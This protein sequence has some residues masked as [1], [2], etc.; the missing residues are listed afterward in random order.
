MRQVLPAGVAAL[1]I[2]LLGACNGQTLAVVENSDAG[3]LDNRKESVSEAEDSDAIGAPTASKVDVLFV[4][5]NSASMSDKSEILAQSVAPFL[6]KVASSGDVHVGVISSSLGGMGGDVCSDDGEQNGRSHLRTLDR[7]TE[8]G[9]FLKYGP[10]GFKDLDGF[11]KNAEELVRKVGQDGCGF[12]AQLE[13]AYRFLAQPDPWLTVVR[14]NDRVRY[15]GIDY[16]LLA[17]RKAFLR[18]DS[19]VVVVLLTDEDDASID[20]RSV[21]GQGFAYVSQSFIGSTVTR[22]D[23]ATTTAARGTSVCKTDPGNDKCT[24]CALATPDVRSTDSECTKNGG[25][26]GPDE[27]SLNVRFHHMK[28]RFGVD[29]RF[30]ISRY[31][32]GFTK[33]LTPNR[34]GEHVVESDVVSPYV[35]NANCTNPLFAASLPEGSEADLCHLPAGSRGKDL[36][37]FA[38]IGGVPETLANPNPDW[39]K[40]L[41]VNPSTFDFKGQDPHM[42]AS[43]NPRNGLAEPTS[44]GNGP[45]PIHG[46]EYDTGGGDLQYAC[47]FALP[48]SRACI[49]SAGPCDCD[50]TRS[51]PLCDPGN[52]KVQIRAKAYPTLRPLELA[53][54]LGERGVIGSICPSGDRPDYGA[55]L[56]ALADRIAPRV[57]P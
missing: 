50:G 43:V 5:D 37:L 31:V 52:S 49:G 17:Q 53:K 10:A 54:E 51:P 6:R 36:V 38:V 24:S 46:R 25:Y 1:M 47:T 34:D 23:G 4:V 48:S 33:R 55:T 56:N 22:S 45:D 2:A 21:N 44:S 40:I 11:V 18:P 16:T 7:A 28:E 8:P 57:Q 15:E 3:V 20:P 14:D 13:S 41:G 29:P 27:D 39:T 26:Y 19:L 42:I 9:G 12:E 35:D 30:P 32:R